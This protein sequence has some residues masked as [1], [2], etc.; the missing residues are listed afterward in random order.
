MTLLMGHSRILVIPL[1]LLYMLSKMN[2]VQKAGWLLKLI[3]LIWLEGQSTCLWLGVGLRIKQISSSQEG[4]FSKNPTNLIWIQN[5]LQSLIIGKIPMELK[6]QNST[7]KISQV[8]LKQT[9]ILLKIITSWLQTKRRTRT[10][11]SW[12][13]VQRKQRSTLLI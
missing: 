10:H 7:F 4:F 13:V 5:Y 11:L 1:Q 8:I 2:L 12:V 6:L 3:R 9:I